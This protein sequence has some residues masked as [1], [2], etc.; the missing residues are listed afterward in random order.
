M[1]ERVDVAVVLP[2]GAAVPVGMLRFHERRRAQTATFTYAESYLS[3][4]RAYALDPRL[5][6][7]AGP[8]HTDADA[9]L[10]GAFADTAPDRWGQNL[11]RRA[12]RDRARGEGVTPRTLMPGDVML[13]VHDELRQ[14]ALRYS[15]PGQG[16]LATAAQGVPRLVELPRLLSL[17]DRL[18]T[19][20]ATD[21]DL[22]DLVNAGGSL[23]G[24]RPK[25]AVRD[26]DGRLRIAK[27]PRKGSDDWDVIAWEALTLDLAEA[28]GAVVPSHELVQVLGRRV[29]LVDRFDRRGT[30]RL[31]YVS[32]MTLT[33]S[34]DHDPAGHSFLEVAEALAPVATSP[35]EDLR[36]LWSRAVF[37]ILV[38]NTDNHLRNHGFLRAADGWRLAPVFDVNPDP[39][40]GAR[41]AVSM[42]PDGDDSVAECIESAE[43]FGMT[44]SDA[45][46]ALDRLVAAVSDWRPRAERLGLHADEIARM[47]AAF[48]STALG[49]A[50]AILRAHRTR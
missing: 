47:R 40:P 9:A 26:T 28:A 17:T 49:E 8:A 16:F 19:D 50:K 22:R 43:Y 30:R 1:T 5:P 15:R 48:D 21:T 45:T 31:G 6:L 13:G 33:E 24:A 37:G 42:T 39:E 35:V 20:G 2:D 12:E 29:L 14:G 41:F 46:E 23:G 32:A 44:R 27:F 18:V 25:A 7:Q 34:A 4:A 3:D 38:N 11:L 36:A 10:F